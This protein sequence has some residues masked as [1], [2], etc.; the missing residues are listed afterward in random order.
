MDETRKILIIGFMGA[1]KTT[2]AHA[3]ARLLNTTCVDLDQ[4]ITDQQGLSPQEIIDAE[5][6]MRFREVE[7]LALE[8]ALRDRA[9]HVISLGGGTW[10]LG[11]NRTIIAEH[12]SFVVWL[13]APFTLCWRRISATGRT[14]PFARDRDKARLRYLERRPLYQLATVHVT[15]SELKRPDIIAEEIAA[16]LRSLQPATPDEQDHSSAKL[17]S[18][19]N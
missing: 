9:A 14:R 18:P 11:Q 2:T 6:E 10:A 19:T 12:R 15:I 4:L 17:P 8:A 3:L 7:T 1:G 13:D 16:M 5:G